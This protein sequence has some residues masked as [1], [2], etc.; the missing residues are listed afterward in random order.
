MLGHDTGQDSSADTGTGVIMVAQQRIMLALVVLLLGA[1]V[2]TGTSAQQL[3]K[4]TDEKGVTHFSMQ[5][6]PASS[7]APADVAQQPVDGSGSTRVY[8]SG[9]WWAQSP[10]QRGEA[11]ELSSDSFSLTRKSIVNGVTRSQ[12]IAEGHLKRDANALVLTYFSHQDASRLD[13]SE[14]FSILRLTDAELELLAPSALQPTLYRRLRRT[15]H[16][17]MQ[18]RLQGDWRVAEQPSR[19]YDFSSGTYRV[20]ATN[21]YGGRLVVQEGNWRWQDPDLQ[22]SPVVSYTPVESGNVENWYL[23]DIGTHEIKAVDRASNKHFTLH[24]IR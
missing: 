13:E 22:L 11:L 9:T 5:P 16:S 4:W 6:P 15:E 17:V 8:L 20:L 23:M 19:V 14:R 24:R 10:G 1:L 3:Y 18:A 21:S 2:T 7:V 12:V